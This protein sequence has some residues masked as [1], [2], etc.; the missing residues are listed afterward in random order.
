MR[1]KTVGLQH[2]SKNVSANGESLNQSCLL[3]EPVSPRDEPTLGT[4]GGGTG[5][6]AAGGV[7]SCAFRVGDLSSMANG[8]YLRWHLLG[9]FT[10]VTGCLL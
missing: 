9:F 7:H 1:S 10:A 8:A 2:R 3:E 5:R 4:S 6:A